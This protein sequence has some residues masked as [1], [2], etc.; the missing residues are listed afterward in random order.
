LSLKSS[1]VKL[2]L[3]DSSSKPVKDFLQHSGN[4]SGCLA[5]VIINVPIAGE[6]WHTRIPIGSI[7]YVNRQH[8][9]NSIIKAASSGESPFDSIRHTDENGQAYWFKDEIQP[10]LN[11]PEICRFSHLSVKT[12]LHT[13]RRQE[14]GLLILEACSIHSSHRYVGSWID[15]L[16]LWESAFVIYEGQSASMLFQAVRCEIQNATEWERKKLKKSKTTPSTPTTKSSKLY[17][18][19]KAETDRIVTA[20]VEADR[21]VLESLSR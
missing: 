19:I 16:F 8:M 14:C 5:S 3:E 1:C 2:S 15:S 4:C 11:I 21:M 7:T 20:T 13:L 18:A 10:V 12:H 9:K 17:R 6:C